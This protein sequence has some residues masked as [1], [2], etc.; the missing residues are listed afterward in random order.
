VNGSALNSG[1]GIVGS[2][3][4]VSGEVAGGVLDAPEV[5][6]GLELP[7]VVTVLLAESLHA[8]TTIE[9]ALTRSIRRDKVGIA[10]VLPV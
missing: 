7:A 3:V 1:T 9:A 4:D 8:A 2:T 6:A 5:P 10:T